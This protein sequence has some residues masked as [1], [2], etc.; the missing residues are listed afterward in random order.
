MLRR[1]WLEIVLA[2]RR[3]R[4]SVRLFTNAT[5]VT[6]DA[7][8]ALAEA[9]VAVETSFYHM[10]EAV[11]EGI[12]GAPGSYQAA[13]RGVELL[14]SHGVDVLLK[15]PVM[16][17]NIGGVGDVRDFAEAVG[18]EMRADPRILRRRDG[19][20][21]PLE[22]RAT[23]D[24]LADFLAQPYA[25]LPPLVEEAWEDGSPC[26]AGVRLAA[27][28]AAGDVL[29]CLAMPEPAGNVN[30][31]SFRSIWEDSAVLRRLRRIRR[32][33]LEVCGDCPQL[34]YCQRCPAQALG[35]DG[36]LL[37]PSA[38]ACAFARA[39]ERAHGRRG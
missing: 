4:F 16:D 3:L 24:E 25:D 26:A 9:S 11:F 20:A 22:L 37:G 10:D 29:A 35:D 27:I 7:A 31:Q 1:D 32:S 34:A 15:V 12:T 8:R 39:V 30:R 28:T 33:D 18:A 19:H 13:R 6:E 14:R 36:D 17:E 23:E 5:R 38:S 21:G 2:A